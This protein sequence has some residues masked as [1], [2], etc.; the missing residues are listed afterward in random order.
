MEK[1]PCEFG[2]CPY[3]GFEGFPCRDFCG[4]GMESENLDF[5][6]MNGNPE[7]RNHLERKNL[8]A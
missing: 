7:L 8:N 3:S 4:L 5:Y 2:S 6:G 1:K